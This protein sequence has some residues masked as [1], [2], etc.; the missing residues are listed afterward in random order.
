MPPSPLELGCSCPP[1]PAIWPDCPHNMNPS[2]GWN[3][4]QNPAY[5]HTGHC[6]SGPP[7]K[8]KIEHRYLRIISIYQERQFLGLLI[9]SRQTT[10]TPE[11]KKYSSLHFFFPRGGINE[12]VQF[13]FSYLEYNSA[14]NISYTNSRKIGICLYHRPAYLKITAHFS[15]HGSEEKE[16]KREIRQNPKIYTDVIWEP[17]SHSNFS[18][19]S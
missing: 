19:Q 17:S 9:H 5:G 2:A 18:P 15:C 14:K 3:H 4:W 13:V 7:G 10:N 6:P 12:L 8:K 1:P 16:R 11:N